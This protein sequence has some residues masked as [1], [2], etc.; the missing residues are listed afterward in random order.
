MRERPIIFTGE[1]VRALLAGTKTQTRRVIKAP[2]VTVRGAVCAD[3]A[4]LMPE[5]RG[6]VA[7][8]GKVLRASLNQHGAVSVVAKDG[9]LLG[10]KPEEF[11]FVC[12]YAAGRTYLDS[13]WHIDV[14]A[15]SRLWMRETFA[16]PWG[17]P[18]RE[19][20]QEGTPW[21]FYRADDEH[22]HDTDGAWRSPIFMPRWASRI[23]LELTDVRVQRLREIGA[24]DVVA[25]GVIVEHGHPESHTGEAC[26]DCALAFA[27]LWDSINVERGYSWD[28]NP[29]V[30]ALTFR[31][32]A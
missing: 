12:P 5:V 28:S 10:V 26:S 16:A 17:R 15:G 20:V 2:K 6:T 11:D 13:G 1:S 25:E 21:V 29:W 14:E 3:L 24:S 27:D 23:T 4:D 31:R 22:K 19:Q 7:L 8:P 30:W 9:R 32:L 18:T